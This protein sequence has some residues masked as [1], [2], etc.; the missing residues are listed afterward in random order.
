MQM[1][2]DEV[3]DP[4]DARDRPAG[5]HAEPA[6]AAARDEPGPAARDA[7]PAGSVDADELIAE[8]DEERPGR[9]ALRRAG[10]G[11]RRGSAS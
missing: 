11:G 5:T 1:R 10:P 4:A 3:P 6:G 7:P 9:A 8:Y 2:A